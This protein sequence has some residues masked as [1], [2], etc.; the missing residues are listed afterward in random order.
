MT[1]HLWE[2]AWD[3]CL[4]LDFNTSSHLNIRLLSRFSPHTTMTEIWIVPSHHKMKFVRWKPLLL[5]NFL[6]VSI[7]CYRSKATVC[8]LGEKQLNFAEEMQAVQPQ[9]TAVRL[10]MH[11]K[12]PFCPSS[13]SVSLLPNA[14]SGCFNTFMTKFTRG[15]IQYKSVACFSGFNVEIFN[16]E[17][18]SERYS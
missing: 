17:G 18:C 16:A 1:T 12:L 8:Q 6:S 2:K 10:A 15:D 13:H 7:C 5:M 3:T 14:L 11:Q 9:T 4:H